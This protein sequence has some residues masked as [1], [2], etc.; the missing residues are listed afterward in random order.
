MTRDTVL[1]GSIVWFSALT[2]RPGPLTRVS[3]TLRRWRLAQTS[4]RGSTRRIWGCRCSC[5]RGPPLTYRMPTPAP[6]RPSP[7]RRPA[8]RGPHRRRRGRGRRPE[9]GVGG[10]THHRQS[11]P[12]ATARG[13]VRRKRLEAVLLPGTRGLRHHEVPPPLH[14]ARSSRGPSAQRGN[15]P[16]S[17]TVAQD[18]IL[19]R[20]LGPVSWGFLSRP[21][22][23]V[24]V[25]PSRSGPPRPPGPRARRA[26]TP[27]APAIPDDVSALT[28]S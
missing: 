21:A 11:L 2:S 4:K 5:M 27:A 3:P 8:G 20:R 15:G 18:A 1:G 23:I 9:R 12:D 7:A 28:N 19:R 25:R 6:G 24:L 17:P 16:R 10:G 22:P 14:R 26:P 13:P